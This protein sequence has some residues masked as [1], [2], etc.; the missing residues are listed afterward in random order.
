M[1]TTNTLTGLTGT[2]YKALDIVAREQVGFIPVSTVDSSA[3]SAAVNQVI[4]SPI[5]PVATLDDVTPG[6]TA[7]NDGGQTITYVDMSIT[8]VKRAPIQWTGEEQLQVGSLANRILQDQFAQAFRALANAVEVDLGAEIATMTT[9][10]RLTGTAGTTPFGTADDLS[11]FANMAVILDE[12][13]APVADRHFVGNYKAKANLMGKQSSL[14]KVNEAGSDRLLR[15]GEV[16]N[17]MGFGI[18]FSPGV[19]LV[20]AGTDYR[21][22]A[23][24]VKGALQLLARAPAVPAGGDSALD[25][26]YVTDPVSGLVFEVTMWGGY[27]QVHIEVALA[28]GV[29]LVKPEFVTILRGESV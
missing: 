26:M 23:A 7:P 17:I 14:F 8:K 12:A 11:D 24:L 27:R 10:G 19:K 22:N 28:W 9:A 13:G 6:V 20:D 4:R 5:A 25:R 1:A 15:A 16:A 2:I 3:V 18:H 29:K 21:A